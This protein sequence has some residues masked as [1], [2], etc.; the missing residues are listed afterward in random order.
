MPYREVLIRLHSAVTTDNDP[1]NQYCSPNYS[2]LYAKR[3]QMY[4]RKPEY[5]SLQ[6]SRLR[7]SQNMRC[8]NCNNVNHTLRTCP[9]PKDIQAII[10]NK[11]KFYRTT[12]SDQKPDVWKRVHWEA[13]HGHYISVV[14]HNAED[15]SF[16]NISTFENSLTED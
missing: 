6:R 9:K 16:L 15:E 1:Q 8:W 3:Q 11:L 4:G 2:T 10:L 13:L 14:P 5:S 12:F 7:P